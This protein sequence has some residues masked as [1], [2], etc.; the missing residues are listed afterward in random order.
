MRLT[1]NEENTYYHV[2]LSCLL[3]KH[4][5]FQAYM[6]KVADSAMQNSSV[7]HRMHL[8]EQFNIDVDKLAFELAIII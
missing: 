3:Q 4:P 1:A 8:K 5:V 7:I 2:M 6:L